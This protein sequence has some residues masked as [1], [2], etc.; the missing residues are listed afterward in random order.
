MKTRIPSKHETATGV[1]LTKE[2]YVA[3]YLREAILAGEITRGTRLK[4][5]ELAAELGLSIT[6]VRE[7][8]KLLVAEGYVLGT[9]HRGAVVAPFEVAAAVEIVELRVLLE[10][11]LTCEAMSRMTLGDMQRIEQL[12]QAFERADALSDKNAARAANYRFHRYL[13]GLAAQPLTFRFVQV[14]WAKYPFDIISQIEGRTGRA[15]R[16]HTRIIDALVSRDQHAAAE[17]LRVHIRSGWAELQ[18][19]M[20]VEKSSADTEVSQRAA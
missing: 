14:L 15:A 1:F 16:E 10:A 5:A 9:T 4:Q 6:P 2:E 13:Y 12:A 18:A 17:A 3:D 19:T 20:S 11:R 8:L 7:A